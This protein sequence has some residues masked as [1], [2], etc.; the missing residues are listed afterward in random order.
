M[1]T[2]NSTGEAQRGDSSAFTLI[3]LLVVI[4]IIAIL[5][6]LMLPALSKARRSAQS[7]Q[8]NSNLRQLQYAWL[9]YASD[10]QDRLVPNWHTWNGASWQSA[11]STSNSWVVGTAFNTDSSAGIHQGA[12]WAYTQNDGIYRCPSD[13]SRWPCSG[14]LVSRSFNVGL[15]VAMNG[16]VNGNTGRTL[17]PLVVLALAEIRR[18][19]GMCTFMDKQEESVTSGLFMVEPRQNQRWWTI[20]GERDRGHGANV[21]FSDGHVSFKKWQCLGRKRS[22]N[23]PPVRNDPDRADRAWLQAADSGQTP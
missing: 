12:I 13:K 17:D 1:P 7:I 9:N 16:G 3:E 10:H 6:S 20:P 4:A 22:E 18:P 11:S 21:A 14:Q 15:S 8:C 19:A 23:S 5:A 2:A